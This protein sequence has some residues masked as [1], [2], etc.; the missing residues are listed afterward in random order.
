MRIALTMKPTQE[1]NASFSEC[2]HMYTF[3]KAQL[4]GGATCYYDKH[5]RHNWPGLQARFGSLAAVNQQGMEATQNML[6]LDIRRAGF[7]P[8]G[9][10]TNA[11]LEGGVE[12]M[13]AALARKR[14]AADSPSKWCWERAAYRWRVHHSG[15][16]DWVDFLLKAGRVLGWVEYDGYW[17][18]YMLV[19][20]LAIWWVSSWRLKRDGSVRAVQLLGEHANYY[21][22]TPSFAHQTAKKARSSVQQF[23]KQRYAQFMAKQ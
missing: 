2:C 23:R 7:G 22:G 6:Q 10:Y 3:L 14:L 4:W 13:A 20:R 9:R 16:F 17:R 11:E 21:H 18:R 19:A 1:Q 8:R 5:I 12:V 15:A